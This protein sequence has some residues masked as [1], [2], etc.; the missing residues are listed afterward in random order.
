MKEKKIGKIERERER[1][2]KKKRERARARVSL[3]EP[4]KPKTVTCGLL[5]LGLLILDL[6][7]VSAFV[8]KGSAAFHLECVLQC[9]P[10]LKSQCFSKGQKKHIKFFRRLRLRETNDTVRVSLQGVPF[11]RLL[12]SYFLWILA[13]KSTVMGPP[14]GGFNSTPGTYLNSTLGFA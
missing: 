9:A 14:G 12:E 4:G 1:E 10:G 11:H 5:V 2:R 8:S 7:R 6:R 3:K 13:E